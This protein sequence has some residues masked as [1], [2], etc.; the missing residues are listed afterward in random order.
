MIV[1][2]AEHDKIMN[3]SGI[4]GY[5][6]SL[7]SLFLNVSINVHRCIFMLLFFQMALTQYHLQ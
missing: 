5:Y 7:A 4:S 1:K 6:C 3:F 2:N